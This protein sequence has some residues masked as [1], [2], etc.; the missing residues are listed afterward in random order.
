MR[1]MARLPDEST[2]LR[3]RH[4]LAAHGLAVQILALVNGILSEKGLMLKAG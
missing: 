1:R 4:L 2:K 3:F